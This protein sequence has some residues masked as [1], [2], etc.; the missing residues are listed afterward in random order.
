MFMTTGIPHKVQCYKMHEA[1]HPQGSLARP[2]RATDTAA[3]TTTT[4]SA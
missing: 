3:A 1:Q 2:Q 4:A